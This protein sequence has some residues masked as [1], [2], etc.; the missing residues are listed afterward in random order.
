MNDMAKDR[1]V[2]TAEDVDQGIDP[3]ELVVPL[4][5]NWMPLLSM[6]LAAGAL[7]VGATFLV[8]PTFTAKTTFMPPQQQQSAAASALASLGALAGLAGGA[9]VRTPADQYVALLQSVTVSDRVI[10]GFDLVQV[11]ESKFR[12]EARKALDR[13]V[14]IGS[15]KKDGLISV[16]VDDTS[17]ERAAAI[18]NRYV[19][20]LRRVTSTL[21]VTEAQ[22]R[23]MFFEKQLQGVQVRL[24]EA[25]RALESSGFSRGALRAEPKAAAEGYARLKAE[26]TAGEVRL[27]AMRRNLADS[28]M[29]VQ[30][31]LA[32]LAALR[33]QL[34]R[35]EQS[36]VSTDGNDYVGRYR[37]FKYQEKLFE[38][39][40]QQ[41]ELAKIDESREG[42]LIQVVDQA[43]PPEHKSAP[44]RGVIGAAVAA[45]AFAGLGLWFVARHVR[46]LSPRGGP[47]LR[48]RLGQLDTRGGS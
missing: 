10:D 21:A 30:Q 31:Q 8:A 29:E 16:E 28:A 1:T 24:T 11:Y 47:S 17:P 45:L 18:A 25:Q 43:Q 44:R 4:L 36:D 26:L 20:E 23:R 2:R 40:A 6:P 39:M 22:Q 41:F 46:R 13:N 34:G 35:L 33:D 37:N 5:A 3:V 12:F 14:R 48:E 27:Q 7:A 19:E 9:G 42:A 32:A 15:G 38:L